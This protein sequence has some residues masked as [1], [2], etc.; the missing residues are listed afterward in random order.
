MHRGGL[1]MVAAT[2]GMFDGEVAFDEAIAQISQHRRAKALAY[3]FERDR[4][5]SLLAGLLL[6]ELLREHGLRECDMAYDESELGKPVFSAHPELQF[7]LAHGG[8]MAVAALAEQPVGVDVERLADFPRD[9]AEPHEWTEMESVGKLLGT[10]VGTYVDSGSYSAPAGV[11]VEHF[12]TCG[13][14]ICLATHPTLP[15][16]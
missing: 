7:S 6:D 2:I 14:L 1:R 16:A 5:L 10:G 15:S 9:I 8:E 12:Q 13:H 11:S 4:R 3:R